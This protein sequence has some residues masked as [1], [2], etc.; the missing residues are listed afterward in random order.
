MIRS[1]PSRESYLP[2]NAA[3]LVLQTLL[4]FTKS[5]AKP[6]VNQLH[7]LL[8]LFTRAFKTLDPENLA[9]A[10]EIVL[11]SVKEHKT[12][13]GDHV[14]EDLMTLFGK[15]ELF[16]EVEAV[17]ELVKP[18]GR[19]RYVKERLER[20]NG[21]GW[22]P[23]S[24]ATSRSFDSAFTSVSDPCLGGTSFFSFSILKP[25]SSRFSSL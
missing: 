9:F 5:S 3:R 13:R 11:K 21:A 22:M 1:L 14:C 7:D 17:W 10:L 15:L 19:V 20:N 18:A 8:H 23:N 6:P 24:E 25:Y 16:D 4:P 2:S 12:L